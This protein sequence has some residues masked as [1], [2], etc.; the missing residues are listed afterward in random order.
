M[1]EHDESFGTDVFAAPTERGATM[2]R[3]PQA[4]KA[5]SLCGISKRKVTR[6][7][8]LPLTRWRGSVDGGL[9]ADA[10]RRAGE[11]DDSLEVM[12]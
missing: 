7:S 6:P 4:L 8:L 2:T 12:M 5:G 10:A 11:R 3:G 9:V 1:A